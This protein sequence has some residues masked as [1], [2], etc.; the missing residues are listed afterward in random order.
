M[1]TFAPIYRRQINGNSKEGDDELVT[2][3]LYKVGEKRFTRGKIVWDFRCGTQ[4]CI[5]DFV[6]PM[7]HPLTVT[8]LKK[9]QKSKK[10]LLFPLINFLYKELKDIF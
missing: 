9:I 7:G 6:F 1:K 5:W 2:G 4:S 8:T 10:V 3:G